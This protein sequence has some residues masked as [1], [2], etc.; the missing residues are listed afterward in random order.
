MDDQ[1]IA[2][3]EERLERLIE[4]AFASVF[5][6]RLRAQDIALQL[7]RAM[8]D[9]IQAMRGG[10]PRPIAPNFYLIRMNP[11]TRA[12]FLQK[13]PD[14]ADILS[15]HMVD[16][17]SSA[18]YRLDTMPHIQII[19]DVALDGGVVLVIADHTGGND[20]AVLQS[21]KTPIAHDAPINPQLLIDGQKTIVLDGGL[22]NIGRSR[23]NQ[24]MLDDPHVSRQHAQI[25]LRFGH[26]MLFDITSQ[27]GTYVNDVRVRE[28]R[29]QPGD[30]VRIGKTRMVYLE[31][32]PPDAPTTGLIRPVNVADDE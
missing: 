26:Y 3:L 17:A 1:Q 25:R 24:I 10:D 28:H 23:K 4:G 12:R 31:D 7:S 32:P 15:R 30:V 19:A 18:G 27:G 29:L 20:T 14:L 2:Q 11:D 21:V 6:K 8:E 16:L 9:G 5:G 13:H 22:I